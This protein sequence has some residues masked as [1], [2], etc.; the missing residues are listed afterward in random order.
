MRGDQLARQWR[1]IQRLARSRYGIGLDELA[2]DLECHRRTVYRDLDALM[3]AGFPVLSERRDGKVFYLRSQKILPDGNRIE[4]G[5]VSASAAEQGGAQ[6]GDGRHLFA[7]MGFLDDSW[8]H[9][10][11]W[12]YG[13]NFAGGHSGYYQAGKYTPEGRILV[14]DK[15]RDYFRQSR[16]ARLGRRL[17]ELIAETPAAAAAVATVL[18][19]IRRTL[20]DQPFLSGPEPLFADHIVCGALQWMR[21]VGGADVL[22]RDDP[23]LAWQREVL[24]RYEADLREI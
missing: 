14:H 22:R 11:Y 1:L 24:D 23:V 17:E 15:D 19:P 6:K 7:P 9:R 5:P 21:L 12:V 2:D 18:E 10:S 4:I 3:F 13:K 8:F 20:Q 16:E